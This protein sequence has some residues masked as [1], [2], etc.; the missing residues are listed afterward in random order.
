MLAQ[1]ALLSAAGQ[2][3]NKQHCM[4]SSTIGSARKCRGAAAGTQELQR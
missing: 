1:Q 2:H 4:K 3:E